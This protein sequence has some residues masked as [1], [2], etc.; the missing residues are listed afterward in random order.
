MLRHR[1]SSRIPRPPGHIQSQS[2]SDAAASG[3]ASIIATGSSDAPRRGRRWGFIA[4]AAV[5]AAGSLGAFAM[6]APMAGTWTGQHAQKMTP[7]APS[8]ELAVALAPMVPDSELPDFDPDVGIEAGDD[9]AD[10]GREAATAI[11]VLKDG[12]RY[13][14]RYPTL[15]DWVH[16]VAAAPE[17]I[18]AKSTRWF[19][20][21]RHG[22]EREECG[23]GHC[24]VDLGGPRG[25]PIV[26]VAWGVV[27]RAE[28]SWMGRDGRSG[29]YVRIEHPDGVY[30]AYMH[31]D[32][33]AEGLDVGDEVQPGQMIGTLGKSGIVNGE[34]HLHFSL[35]V[36]GN[37]RPQFLDPAPFLRR[38]RVV[39][40][41][42]RRRPRPPQW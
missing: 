24:G 21:V 4:A 34:H 14:E 7:P 19:G 16:P 42:D 33:I 5:L 37:G 29:R 30:T 1:S 12:E 20:A 18:P 23:A 40:A 26:A 17:M 2:Q 6:R 3:G 15:H 11:P 28:R 13:D 31:L 36:P 39:S 9:S 22:V 38:A 8:T 41:P 10:T 25:Q 27:V 35:E 32:D